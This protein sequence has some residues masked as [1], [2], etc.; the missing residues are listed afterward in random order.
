M[1]T[2]K[3]RTFREK[4]G[5]DSFRRRKAQS[6]SIMLSPAIPKKLALP[7]LSFHQTKDKSTNGEV[8]GKKQGL[9]CVFLLAFRGIVL[10]GAVGE[11][12]VF[13]WGLHL[14]CGLSLGFLAASARLRSASFCALCAFGVG[15]SPF[16]GIVLCFCVRAVAFLRVLWV[17]SGFCTLRFGLAFLFCLS[18]V[19]GVPA[20]WVTCA[21]L[22]GVCSFSR[23]CAL[24]RERAGRGA[25]FCVGFLGFCVQ[26]VG[27]VRASF[28]S[29]QWSFWG[30]SGGV[31]FVCGLGC[32]AHQKSA[33]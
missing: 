6:L 23:R 29:F 4:A 18:A 1:N 21:F 30:L 13:A 3:T 31:S 14:L 11:V 7:A 19:F 24:R 26:A 10:L 20:W 15:C 27:W 17:C 28:V 16:R 22:H 5:S 33:E 25:R 9:A 8:H 12:R 2:Y 32:R